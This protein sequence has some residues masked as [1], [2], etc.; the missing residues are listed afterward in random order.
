M[1]TKGYTWS[2]LGRWSQNGRPEV[3]RGGRW[4]CGLYSRR[5]GRQL[6][7][8][9]HLEC[10]SAPNTMGPNLKWR[11]GQGDPHLRLNL[12]QE[13][14]ARVCDGEMV[15]PDMSDDL[16]RR[17]PSSKTRSN[18]F[19]VGSSPSSYAPITARSNESLAHGGKSTLGFFDLRLKIRANLGLLTYPFYLVADFKSPRSKRNRKGDNFG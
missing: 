10:S 5:C 7:D 12:A 4:R 11:E 18:N 2:N 8:T 17:S 19:V 13:T 14:V 16:L 1:K 9:R 15:S 6:A 3:T